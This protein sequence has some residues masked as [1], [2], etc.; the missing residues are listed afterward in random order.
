MGSIKFWEVFA[1]FKEICRRLDDFV[2]GQERAQE[3]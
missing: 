3:F 2:V 1:N